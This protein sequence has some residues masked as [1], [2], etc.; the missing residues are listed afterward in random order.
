VAVLRADKDPARAGHPGG[1]G[2]C[3]SYAVASALLD[4]TIGLCG[5]RWRAVIGRG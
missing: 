1:D 3:P 2:W 4:E 5:A